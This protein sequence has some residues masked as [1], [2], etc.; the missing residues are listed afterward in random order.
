MDRLVTSYERRHMYV[1]AARPVK[2]QL[3]QIVKVITQPAI[4]RVMK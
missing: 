3:I 1:A 4:Y 2:L